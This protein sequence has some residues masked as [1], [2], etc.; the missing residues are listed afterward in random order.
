MPS[1]LIL[2]DDLTG[3][4]DCAARCRHAGMPATIFL[5]PPQP[6]LPPGAV[7]FTSDSRHLSPEQAAERVR[8]LVAPLRHLSGVPWYKK[9]DSTLRGNLGQELDAMLDVLAFPCAV[10][11][12][13]FPAQKRGLQAGR[14]VMDQIGAPSIHLPTHL[15]QQSRHEVAAIALDDVRSGP[16]QLASRLAAAQAQGARHLVVD[17]LTESDLWAVLAAARTALP[18]ALLCGSAGLVSVLAAHQAAQGE[19]AEA[20]EGT[21]PM[22]AGPRLVVV[23][24]GSDMAHRQIAVLQRQGTTHIEEIQAAGDPLWHQGSAG[25]KRDCLLHLPRPADQTVLEGPVARIFVARLAEAVDAAVEQ[26]QPSVLILVGGD[27]AIHVLERLNVRRLRVLQELLPGMPLTRSVD[28]P[29]GELFVVLK[30][31]N[32]GDAQTLIELLALLKETR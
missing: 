22:P 1:L 30:A 6:P 19:H 11:S 16:D 29:D 18:Q 24:S 28:G 21:A 14:L 12:P 5:D 27:T 20:S 10:I 25:T 23:G 4:A 3:T 7:A 32:H 15:G 26:L 17:A 2:A 9:I 31:G 13:A 8:I